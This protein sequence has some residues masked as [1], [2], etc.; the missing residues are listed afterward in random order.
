MDTELNMW[1]SVIVDQSSKE[2]TISPDPWTEI[3]PLSLVSGNFTVNSAF[4][5]PSVQ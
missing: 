5:G 2:I 3:R 4:F 1:R